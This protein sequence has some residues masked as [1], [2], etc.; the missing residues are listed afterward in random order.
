[1][2]LQG[3]TRV[4]LI[5]VH[6]AIALDALAWCLSGLHAQPVLL[7]LDEP[8]P[9]QLA[10]DSEPIEASPASMLPEGISAKFEAKTLADT[11]SFRG[12]AV[13]AS[14]LVIAFVLADSLLDEDRGRVESERMAVRQGLGSQGFLALAV[15]DGGC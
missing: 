15:A 11:N 9:D 4:R 10:K 3:N 2:P 8:E 14:E 6:R 13:A 1:M 5:S 7:R 12:H